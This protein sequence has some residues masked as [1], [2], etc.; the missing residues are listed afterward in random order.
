MPRN[1]TV[2]AR[3]RRLLQGAQHRARLDQMHRK[4]GAKIRHAFA[5]RSASAISV[6]RPGPELDEVHALR[7]S[8]LLPDRRGPCADQ[9]AEHL[10]DFR[11]G[12]EITRRAERIARDVIAVVR[13]ARG[14][15]ACSPATGIGPSVSMMRRISRSER[16]HRAAC[17]AFSGGRR[18]AITISTTPNSSSGTDSTM[19]MVSPPQRKPSCASGSR[20][21]SQNERAIA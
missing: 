1:R 11:R 21:S 6:P 17:A 2:D 4:R 18:S 9:L 5:A 12:D 7:R 3:E 19:P 14:R 10:A 15:A 16:R 13:M 8:H 20:N